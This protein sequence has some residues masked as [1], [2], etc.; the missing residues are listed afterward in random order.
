MTPLCKRAT[1]WLGDDSPKQ[2]WKKIVLLADKALDLL[3][4]ACYING[5]I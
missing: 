4:V 3:K 5:F 2:N 1:K